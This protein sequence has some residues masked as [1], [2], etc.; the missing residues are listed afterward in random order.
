MSGYLFMM[1]H[2]DDKKIY[3]LAWVYIK[4][5]YILRFIKRQWFNLL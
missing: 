4:R 2:F 5:E 1:V 3:E